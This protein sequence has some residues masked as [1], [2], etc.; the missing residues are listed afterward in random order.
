MVVVSLVEGG[1]RL[2]LRVVIMCVGL[3]LML[4][5]RYFQRIFT[6]ESHINCNGY[7]SSDS[8]MLKIF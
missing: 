6:L 2:D 1:G 8:K 4:Y 3:S 7:P 5:L